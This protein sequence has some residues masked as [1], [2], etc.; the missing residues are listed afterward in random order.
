MASKTDGT[1]WIWGKNTFGQMG[2]NSAIPVDL[3]SPTQIPGTGWGT[4]FNKF[5]IGQRHFSIIKGT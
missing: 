4:T 5:G 1:L 2:Q 3:S